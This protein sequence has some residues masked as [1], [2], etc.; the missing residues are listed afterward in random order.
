AR[1]PRAA[2][3]GTAPAPRARL[4]ARARRRAGGVGRGTAAGD[5]RRPR[6]AGGPRAHAAGLVRDAPRGG[7]RLGDRP[8]RRALGTRA[9]ARRVPRAE[10]PVT[11]AG[12]LNVAVVGLGYWGKTLLRTFGALPAARVTGLCDLAPAE[13]VRSAGPP[14]GARDEAHHRPGRPGRGVPSLLRA[15]R[16]GT[17]QARLER[18]VELGAARPLHPPLPG[19]A[20]GAARP[21][22]RALLPPAG[23]RRHG[24]GRPR[25][26]GRRLGAHLPEL[27]PPREDRHRDGHR[28]RAHARLRGSLREARPHALRLRYRALERERRRER[29]A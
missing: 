25:A 27:A 2:D 13:I 17:H 5:P 20:P 11:A 21:P 9:G 8:R 6:V 3:P 29:R 7:G 12:R 18:V 15:P 26:R 16:D 10:D 23:R 28:A 1:P 4:R 22:A 24:R 19:V 14:P